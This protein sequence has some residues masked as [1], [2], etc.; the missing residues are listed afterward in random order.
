MKKTAWPAPLFGNLMLLCAACAS[1]LLLGCRVPCDEGRVLDIPVEPG[2][3]ASLT[4]GIVLDD[5]LVT[6][7]A[8]DEDSFYFETG[9]VYHAGDCCLRVSGCMRN[10]TAEG[11][12]VGFYARGYD[13]TGQEVAHQLTSHH[14]GGHASLGVFPGSSSNFDIDL[15][16]SDSV[17]GIVM[18][19][20]TNPAMWP[21]SPFTS[22]PPLPQSEMTRITFSRD[23][24][25]ENDVE[26]NPATIQVTFPSSWLETQ[27]AIPEGEETVV[28]SVPTQLLLDSNTSKNM[29]E[30]TVTLPNRYFKG[31]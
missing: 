25:L 14:L 18:R 30:L 6:I 21:Y 3:G 20:Y 5:L 26:P 23:W 2:S 15:T 7:G 29:E 27:P 9:E 24:L 4:E 22:S 11:I 8:L 13:S 31:L 1:E 17:Q 10:T 19:G 16:W 12:W 28:L